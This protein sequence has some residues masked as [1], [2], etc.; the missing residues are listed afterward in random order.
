MFHSG[1]GINSDSYYAF[2]KKNHKMTLAH[3]ICCIVKIIVLVVIFAI[4][5]SGVCRQ[6]K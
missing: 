4:L 1:L 3:T 5:S 2:Q 6:L